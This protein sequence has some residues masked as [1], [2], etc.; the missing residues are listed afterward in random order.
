MVGAAEALPLAADGARPG[1]RIHLVGCRYD[2]DALWAYSGGDVS[3][4]AHDNW[5][6]KRPRH[7]VDRDHRARSN[8]AQLC[9]G[10]IDK[11]LHIVRVELAGHNRKCALCAGD[12]GKARSN[13]VRHFVTHNVS[14]A[15][16]ECNCAT[17][18][19]R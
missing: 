19:K 18:S 12:S 17:A 7:A 10:M 15:G 3:Q 11:P 6:L 5:N 4:L 8:F 9:R 1:D 2:I 16:V 14:A 13:Q